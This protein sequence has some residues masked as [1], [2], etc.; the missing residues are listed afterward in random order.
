MAEQKQ[1]QFRVTVKDPQRAQSKVLVFFADLGGV[2]WEGFNFS[3][4]GYA[5]KYDIA[6]N[7]IIITITQKPIWVF[8]SMI[9]AK[10]RD[11]FKDV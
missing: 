9:V 6:G 8:N 3:G 4:H 11:F 5:G 1:F 7:D 10:A 2:V